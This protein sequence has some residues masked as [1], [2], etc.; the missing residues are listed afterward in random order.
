MDTAKK[1]D[2]PEEYRLECQGCHK[3][4]DLRDVNILQHGWIEDGEIVCYDEKP[5]PYSSSRRLGDN[6]E[7]TR[8]KKPMN[9]N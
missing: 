7:W 4:L 5:M 8:D 3:I 6:V 1:D 9:L 2:I